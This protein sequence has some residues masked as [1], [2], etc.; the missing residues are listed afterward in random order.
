MS[1]LPPEVYNLIDAALSEDQ[2][3]NDPTTHAL[4]PQ[5]IQAVG[6]IRAKG[7]GML[8]GIEICQ[9]VFQRID[10]SNDGGLMVLQ[11]A[12]ASVGGQLGRAYFRKMHNELDM[13]P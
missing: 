4:V 8:A 2:A 11:E 13:I 7:N 6:K 3:F 1:Q 9:A 5:G 12:F 10:A